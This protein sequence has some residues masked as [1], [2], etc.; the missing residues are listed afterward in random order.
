MLRVEGPG[1]DVEGP[2]FDVE[3][4][5]RDSEEH[6]HENVRQH[7]CVAIEAWDFAGASPHCREGERQ[8]QR[9]RRRQTAMETETD[10]DSDR[11]REVQGSGFPAA[12]DRTPVR[13][14]RDAYQG[15]M[16]RVLS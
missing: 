9:Q 10:S 15:S 4:T 12:P 5:V 13:V 3:G 2:G 14:R 7:P 1:F 6:Q 11:D 16:W 8:R